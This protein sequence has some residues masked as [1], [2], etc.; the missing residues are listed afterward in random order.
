MK[1]K[2]CVFEYEEER[3]K[4]LMRA[5]REQLEACDTIVLS[6]VLKKVVNMPSCRFWVSEERVAIVVARMMKGDK[7]QSMRQNTREMFFEIYQRVMEY[8]QKHPKMPL[9]EIAFHVVRQQ[10]PKFYL[11]PSSAQKII[12]S[13]KKKIF[14]K[15]KQQLRHMFNS[16]GN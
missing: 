4:D 8:R 11:T 6:E 12:N 1:H 15:R 10:A 16:S 2:G 3:N 9:T 13:I 7:L 5:Y 14:E